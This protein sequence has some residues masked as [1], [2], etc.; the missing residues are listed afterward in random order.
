MTTYAATVPP[1]RCARRVADLLDRV[2]RPQHGAHRRRRRRRPRRQHSPLMS[3]LVW[4]LAHIGNQEE[5]WLVRDVGG[6]EPLRPEIDELYDAFQHSRA[7]RVELPLLTP[8]RGARVRRGGARQGAGRAGPQPAATAGGSTRRLRVRH[9]R[10]ARAA[11][12]RDDARHPPAARRRRRCCAAPAATRRARRCPRREV[13]VPGGAVHDGHVDRAVGAGQRAAGARGRRAGVLDR[14]GAGDQRRVRRVRRRRRLRRPRW[15]TRGGLGAPRRG[16]ARRAARSGSATATAVVAAPV[17]R[18]RAGARRRAGGARLL[19][20]GARRTPAWAGKRLPTEAEWEKAARYDP[21]TGAVAALPWGDDDP[22]PAHA[23]LGQRHLQPAPGGRVPG[24]RVAA[25]RAPAHRRRLGVDVA[26]ASPATRASRRSRTG[27]TPRCSSAATTGAARRL[28][29]HRPAAVPRARSATGTTRSAGRSSPASA[30]PATPRPG[31]R[32]ADVPPPGLPRP[33]DARSSALLLDPPH[34]LLRQSWAPRDMRG[35]GTVNADG[36]GVG[37]YPPGGDAPLRYRSGLLPI[38]A[39]RVRIADLAPAT[40]RPAR[41]S[42]R[43]ARRRSACRSTATAAAP[44]ADGPVAVQPQRRGRAAGPTRWPRSPPRCRSPTCSPSTPRPTRRCCGRWCAHRLRAATTRPRRSPTSSPRSRPPRRGRGSTCCSPT[45]PASG[46]RLG[47]RAVGA[48][49]ARRTSWSPPSRSTTIPG[50]PTCPTDTWSSPARRPH[51]T[52]RAHEP[53]CRARH[54]IESAVELDVHL[55]EHDAEAALRADVR[56]GLTATPKC[57]PPKWFY[58]ARGSELFEE[59]TRLPEYYPTRAEREP[60]R[61][62]RSTR[63][64]R[65]TGRRH[66]GRAGLGVVGEDPA[67]ARRVPP[68]RH[69]GRATSRWTCS[70]PALRAALD[71]LAAEYP[72]LACTGSSPTSPGT[73]TGCPGGARRL[74]A[75]LGGTIGNL[76]P[77]ERAAFLAALRGRARAGRAAAAR[78]RPGQ[79]PATYWCRRTTTPPG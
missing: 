51:A 54:P 56:A 43:C 9:D 15:W 44:F 21:A 41:C 73:S 14:H 66:A 12:R 55:T 7:S 60:A 16:R 57:L 62:A 74:V 45:A 47:P 64:P 20:R 52:S 19:L 32:S 58:D 40:R 18:G 71:A 17:R 1:R 42:P 35:G 68:G 63:S 26:R 24:G 27:S 25:G 30:A 46:H 76:L 31:R 22:T 61:R 70:A 67:A 28:V 6:R 37:W 72:G 50:G 79:G 53:A 23:N 38:W 77:A 36:F 65:V 69:A 39:D 48:R 75:F 8:G 34:G 33:A 13:L 5:L 78:H 2:P 29:R 11:A 10:P 4:D 3:P 59:I 49:R